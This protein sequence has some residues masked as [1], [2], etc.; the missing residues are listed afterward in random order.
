MSLPK[1]SVEQTTYA[2]ERAHKDLHV[3][4]LLT[5]DEFYKNQD[6]IAN[7]MYNNIFFLITLAT[8]HF[9]NQIKLQLTF[10]DL[11]IPILSQKLTLYLK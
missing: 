8:Y 6:E 1:E 7:L 5:F 9:S 10:Y 3:P 2:M 4:F 11:S